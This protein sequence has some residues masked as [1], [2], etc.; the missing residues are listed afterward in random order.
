MDLYQ[1][2]HPWKLDEFLWV[3][4]K[5]N[6]QGRNFRF[7]LHLFQE[8]FDI[9]VLAPNPDWKGKWVPYEYYFSDMG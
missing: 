6:K 2:G 7:S 4:N 9:V 3:D 8:C 1:G 5:A